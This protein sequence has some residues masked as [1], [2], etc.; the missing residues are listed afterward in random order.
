[1]HRPYRTVIA[2]SSEE[3]FLAEAPELPG[4]ISAGESEDEAR[5]NLREAMTGWLMSALARG[6]P[7]PDPE[8]T[9]TSH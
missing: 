5:A 9:R 1:M 3:G 6:L 2:G 7:V 4:C 8:L